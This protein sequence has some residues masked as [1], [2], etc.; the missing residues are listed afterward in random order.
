MGINMFQSAILYPQNSLPVPPHKSSL[1]CLL[2]SKPR[3]ASSRPLPLKVG[4]VVTTEGKG[5]GWWEWCWWRARSWPPPSRATAPPKPLPQSHSLPPSRV[6]L[7]CVCDQM[8]VLDWGTNLGSQVSTGCSWLPESSR[9]P[10]G[11]PS[12]IIAES[13]RLSRIW[14]R[15]A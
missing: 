1:L 15:C 3:H 11:G 7:F 6:S 12:D 10:T 9:L 14:I 8:I 2:P 5:E 13:S 4:S